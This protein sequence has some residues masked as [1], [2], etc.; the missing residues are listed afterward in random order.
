MDSDSTRLDYRAGSDA[1][2]DD[3]RVTGRSWRTWVV[4]CAVWL[5]GLGVWAVYLAALGYAVVLL[6]G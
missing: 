5:I 1:A 4:L 6:L 2:A 3:A